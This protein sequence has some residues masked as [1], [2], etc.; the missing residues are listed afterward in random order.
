[1]MSASTR[2]VIGGDGRAGQHRATLPRRAVPVKRRGSH[3]PL[4]KSDNQRLISRLPP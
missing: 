3:A 2:L 4:Q 1:M